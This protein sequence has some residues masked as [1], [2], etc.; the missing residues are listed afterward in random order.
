[1]GTGFSLANKRFVIIKLETVLVG[2]KKGKIRK[3]KEYL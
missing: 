2:G 1:M 3:H